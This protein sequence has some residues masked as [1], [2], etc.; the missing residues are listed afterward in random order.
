MLVYLS[1]NDYEYEY[2]YCGEGQPCP[3][4]AL[5]WVVSDGRCDISVSEHHLHG[6]CRSYATVEG[7]RK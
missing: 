6:N 4:V 3:L 7:G 2:G 5:Q 1:T